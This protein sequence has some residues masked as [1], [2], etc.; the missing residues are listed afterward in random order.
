MKILKEFKEFIM[1]GNVMDMAVGVIVGG[2][3]SK[4]VTAVVNDLLNP[5][6]SLV[7]GNSSFENMFVVLR[8]G[9]DGKTAYTTLAEATEAGATILA[10]G[11]VIQLIIDFLL[12]ALCLFLLVKGVNALRNR[13]AKLRD[14]LLKKA[15][16]PEQ[17]PA[18]PEVPAEPALTKTEELL[19][20][21]KALL[22]KQSDK[23]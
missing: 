22:E 9:T 18:E 21:I 10:W 1:R 23:E 17:A 12:T 4:I 16:E 5:L 13:E 8:A 3:F 15:E 2:M 20:E 11:D 7:T 14:A 6:V 19:T